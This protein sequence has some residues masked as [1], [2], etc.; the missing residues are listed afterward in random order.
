MLL[1]NAAAVREALPMAVAID[2][3]KEA[4]AALA[5]G[6]AE[7][8]LRL[9]L[10]VRPHEGT[11][12]LMPAYVTAESGDALAVKII[13]LFDR[14]PDKGLARI[15]ALVV[16]L[17]PTT[18]EP[19]ALL[20]GGALT[21]IRTAGAS[22]AATEL[23]ARPDSRIAAIFGAGVQAR[24]Q[25][26]A[27]CTVRP[28]ETVWVYDPIGGAAAT[29]AAEMAGR[30]PI[31]D[32]VRSAED[33]AQAVAEAD[34]ICTAT[35]SRTPVFDDADLKG[36]VHINA[37]GSYQPHVQEIAPETVLRA[38]LIV[39]DREAAL[40]ETGDLI[41]PIRK[42]LMTP[43]HIAADLGQVVLG[44]AA[45]RRSAEEITLFKSVGVAVQDTVAAQVAVERAER[46]GIGQTIEW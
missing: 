30:G 39:D 34:V 7:A 35:T 41:Q 1:L 11:T 9:H 45:G 29:F 2:A 10:F 20:A 14:N 25:L 46:L 40:D 21:A 12:V 3:M 16:A 42:G 26:E 37:I 44:E 43:G 31:P 13:S 5:S 28:I 6:R 18:G 22:G 38:R 27:V 4:F 32:D 36:G 33:P 17:K 15:Q 19:V 23:M 8:P 24:A